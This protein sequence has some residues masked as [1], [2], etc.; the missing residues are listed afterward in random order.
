MTGRRLLVLGSVCVPL[1]G[2][3][4]AREAYLARARVRLDPGA[5][6]SSEPLTAAGSEGRSLLAGDS[7]IAQWR[8]ATPLDPARLVQRG[9]PGETAIH[10]A[11]RLRA[12]LPAFRPAR[13]V[14]QA[15]IND[16]VAGAAL[17]RAPE[18]AHAAANAIAGI[19][20]QA[21]DLGVPVV[22]LTVPP[23]AQAHPW[24]SLFGFSAAV[25]ALPGLNERIRS[26]ASPAV[27]LLDAAALLAG[28]AAVL[29][30]AYA[31]DTLHWT[32]AAYRLLDQSLAPL[33]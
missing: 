33:V 19:V 26:M 8:P 23:P 28:T 15:G 32:S 1:A 20:A 27:V 29:P 9:V 24:R 16:L 25:A 13:L 22:L 12:E 6:R 14:V 7:R 18:A 3:A 21:R 5:A 4:G 10:L 17:G 30:A 31:R 2:L 11:D